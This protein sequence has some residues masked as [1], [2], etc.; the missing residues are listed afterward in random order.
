MRLRDSQEREQT[1]SFGGTTSEQNQL[2]EDLHCIAPTTRP[3]LL[4]L[5]GHFHTWPSQLSL[6]SGCHSL[7]HGHPCETQR[8]LSEE[9]PYVKKQGGPEAGS[10]EGGGSCP[11]LS[12]APYLHVG[13]VPFQ[14][15]LG[16]RK[17]L[18]PLPEVVKCI[19]FVAQQYSQLPGG[20][21]ARK[22]KR[23]IVKLS[24]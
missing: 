24:S 10:G 17:C 22:N 9:R 4:S 19:G 7:A 20:N 23:V 6:L 14:T 16:R 3:R 12:L 21:P 8:E 5:P 18:L 1:M 11:K 2:Q 13:R 15:F